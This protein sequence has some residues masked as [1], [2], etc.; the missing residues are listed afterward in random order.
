VYSIFADEE[1]TTLEQ[2]D[3]EDGMWHMNFD[4]S[5]SNEGNRAGIIVYSPVGK[6]HN[7][8]Y[9]LDF[10]CTNN[11]AG[12]EELLL[13]IENAYNLGCG[14]L[15][16]FWDSKL[17]VNLVRKIY[18]PRNKLLKCDTQIVWALISNL[19][20]F[21]ITHVKM[22]LNLMADKLVVFAASPTRQLLP[23]RPDCTFQ[24]L[25]HPH[26]ADNVESWQVFPSDESIYDFIQNE[27]YNPKEIISMEDNKISKGLTPLESS[28]SSS[29]V[30]NKE[31]HKEEES[32]RKV[33]E[34]IFLNIGTPDSPKNV[35]IGAQCSDEYK[36][37]FMELLRK[38]QDVFSWYYEDLHGFDPSLIQ[39]SIPIKEG[40]KS[41]RQK[42][43]PINPALEATIRKELEKFLKAGIIFT[44]KYSEWVSNLVPIRKIT[45]RIRLCIDFH[46]LNRAS[47]KDHFRLSNMEMILQQVAGSQMMSLLECFS[48]YNLIKVKMTDK[49]KTTF[50]TSWGTFT[51]ERIPFGLSNAGATFQRSIQIDFD[52]LIGKIIHIYLDEL[53]MYSKNQSD[54]FVHLRKV[55][56]RCRKFVISLNPSKSIF[57][58][59]KGKLLGYIVSNSRISIDPERIATI[60]NLPAPTS[61]KEVQAFMGIINFVHTFFP[62][63]VVMVKPIHN[64]LKKDLSFSWTD[65][66]EN[67]FVRIKK[68]INSAPILAKLDFE[69]EFIV[70]TNAIEEAIY[71][72]LM[73]FDDQFNKKTIAYMSQSLS[74]DEFKYS[75][76]EKHAFTLV[77]GVEKFYHF[78]LGKH[79]LV[80]FPLPTVKFFLS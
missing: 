53:T 24:Y 60:L 17:V 46:T 75:Y 55:L 36:L 20:S 7:F 47:I 44:V 67:N 74:N 5:C 34:T 30:G 39:H 52:D 31:K 45:S 40:I 62:D 4:G 59:T 63:F 57:S 12:F 76:I 48:G 70:Y 2:I 22:E 80:K 29:D 73:Q 54:H 72:I 64:I 25:Y 1:N 77:K 61:K 35:N 43:R 79:T 65:D 10:S 18:S 11:I 28:F 69:K 49:Y 78:I 21:N 51:Y 50:I 27:P 14:H 19:L 8:S 3:L 6:I 58:V 56:I 71:D 42:Q 16:F 38:F 26:I 68:E 15:T 33:G 32:K 9:R 41:V 66:V 13:G 23:Q 37:K